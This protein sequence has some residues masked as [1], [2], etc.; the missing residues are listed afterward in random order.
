MRPSASPP[1]SAGG[2]GR[3]G[4]GARANKRSTSSPRCASS[5]LHAWATAVCAAEA[6][7]PNLVNVEVMTGPSRTGAAAAAAHSTSV[8]ACVRDSPQA[9]VAQICA[10]VSFCRAI[11]LR[12]LSQRCVRLT[13]R[14]PRWRTK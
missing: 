11:V 13:R 4:Q 10:K 8:L 7:G 14:K 2:T 9:E 12:H 5:V 1:C 6:W 3:C